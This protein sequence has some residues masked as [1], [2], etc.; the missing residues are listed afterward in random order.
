MFA[1]IH[2]ILMYAAVK[3]R[4]STFSYYADQD[5][6]MYNCVECKWLSK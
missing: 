6:T 1:T 3:L 5:I 4:L 2:T